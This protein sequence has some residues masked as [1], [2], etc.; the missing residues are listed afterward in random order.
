[1]HRWERGTLRLLRAVL[2]ARRSR[3]VHMKPP[4]SLR[5]GVCS[6]VLCVAPAL[7]LWSNHELGKEYGPFWLASNQ[8][9]SYVYLFSSLLI[10]NGE[11]PF[12]IDHPGT[13]LQMIGAAVIRASTPFAPTNEINKSV[14]GASESYLARI[15]DVLVGIAVVALFLSGLL[16][17]TATG[18]ILIALV[19]QLLVVSLAQVHE[20][21]L[22]VAPEPLLLS[23]GVL[24]GS[25]FCARYSWP[26]CD[27]KEDTFTWHNWLL[28]V[29]AGLGLATKVT[30]APL[31]VLPFLLVRKLRHALASLVLLAFA[32]LL[33]T[34]PAWG[35]LPRMI[36]W[37]Y[38]LSSHTGQYGR[39]AVG[40][41]DSTRY[42]RDVLFL[43]SGTPALPVIW[44][45][46]AVYLTVAFCARRRRRFLPRKA[47]VLL[48]VLL[49]NV[50]GVLLVAKHPSPRYLLPVGVCTVFLVTLALCYVRAL[51]AR[52]EQ[53]VVGTGALVLVLLGLLGLYR[54]W[55]GFENR[56]RAARLEADATRKV[57]QEQAAGRPVV[58]YYRCSTPEYALDLG[59]TYSRRRFASILKAQEESALFLHRNGRLV[60]FSGPM[61]PNKVFGEHDS[62]LFIGLDGIDTLPSG[63]TLRLPRTWRKVSV[64]KQ[65]RVAIDVLERVEQGPRDEFPSWK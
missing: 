10:A 59:N 6:L 50:L 48:A 32:F 47:M 34:L 53:R 17:W 16:L 51:E 4:A 24:V 21:I 8:D 45:S 30:F 33:A 29:V 35:E 52:A 42:W 22:A 60:S 13:P 31:C 1:M 40:F 14:V 62:L 12:H 43:L 37:L 61:K 27:R 46:V 25:V 64:L 41:V 63:L 19:S 26:E 38:R 56:L 44:T 11:P 65:G 23:F 36:A 49:L 5:L 57:L 18:S 2:A 39:G 9:P 7:V 3:L 58:Q 15:H 54:P 28:P 20:S 55:L